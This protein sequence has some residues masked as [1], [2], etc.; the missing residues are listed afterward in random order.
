MENIAAG[1]FTDTDL[2]EAIQSKW[3]KNC[4]RDALSNWQ[5]S[6]SQIQPCSVDLYPRDFHTHDGKRAEKH[7]SLALV[8]GGAVLIRTREELDLPDNIAG[9]VFTPTHLSLRGFFSPS[10]GH[11]DPG[12]KGPLTLV[13]INMGKDLLTLHDSMKVATIVLYKLNRS[14]SRDYSARKAAAQRDPQET[15]KKFAADFGNF[16]ATARAE[17]GDVARGQLL[18]PLVVG[19]FL[20]VALQLVSSF[21]MGI[22]QL[23]ED[24]ARLDG[25]ISAITSQEH[26]H[27]TPSPTPAPTTQRQ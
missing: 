26:P 12:Y 3:L 17:A 10:I 7:T 20:V 9:F 13:G 19:A 27:P 1:I 15:I 5:G 14:C 22:D 21:I 4:D 11:I 6:S 25:R 23:K 8:A 24:V 2:R 18:I 16:R